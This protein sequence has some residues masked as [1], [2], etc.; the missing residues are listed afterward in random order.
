MVRL[1]AVLSS[2]LAAVSLLA[3]SPV[4]GE[5]PG[6]LLGETTWLD[7]E[8]LLTPDAVIVIPIGAQAKEHGPHLRLDNDFQMAEYYK[9]RVVSARNVVMLPT[10]NYHFYPAFL[11]YPG[12]THLSYATSIQII[13][14]IVRSIARH[15]PRKFYLLNTGVSTLRPIRAAEEEL[16]RDGVLMTYLDIL[17]VDK[18]PD[19]AE[20]IEQEG[21]THAEE[22][23]TSVMLYIEQQTGL[24]LVDEA[25]IIDEYNAPVGRGGLTREK[26]KS[27]VFSKS[28]VYGTPSLASLEKGKVFTEATVEQILAD[29]D[30]LQKAPLP[31]Q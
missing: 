30:A 16:S 7:A 27:G 18:R 24:D 20:L 4:A 23:E 21:G 1:W 29:I 19:V 14:D 31:N 15:G 10:L 3:P 12:S 8:K 6:V 17:E 2:V 25:K 13:V 22:T 5:T 9:N 26:G 28:G 11:E